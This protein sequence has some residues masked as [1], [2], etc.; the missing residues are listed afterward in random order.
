MSNPKEQGGKPKGVLWRLFHNPLPGE[1]GSPYQPME[2]LPSINH[3]GA[4]DRKRLTTALE[5]DIANLRATGAVREAQ[6]LE[7]KVAELDAGAKIKFP[8]DGFGDP[9]AVRGPL[10]DK[11]YTKAVALEQSGNFEEAKHYWELY[12]ETSDAIDISVV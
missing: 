11:Y 3:V 12:R 4:D 10:A 7:H 5:R 1:E 8:P 9:H 6:I 2:L